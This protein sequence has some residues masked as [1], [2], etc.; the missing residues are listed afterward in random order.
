VGEHGHMGKNWKTF[1]FTNIFVWKI[2]DSWDDSNQNNLN[3]CQVP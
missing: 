2:H 1:K 3:N